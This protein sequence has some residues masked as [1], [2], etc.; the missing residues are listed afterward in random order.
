MIKQNKLRPLLPAFILFILLNGFFLSGKSMLEKWDADQGV[1]LIGNLILFS[2]TLVSY[3]LSIRG[4]KSDNPHA[5]VRSVYGSFMVK[6][7]ICIIAAFAYI[8]SEKK[9]V[10]KPALF[11]C[12]GLYIVYS[13]IEVSVLTK[14]SKQKKNA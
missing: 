14:L 4:L 9:N 5:A 12:M 3:L 8:M 10:N 2:V 13:V 6:F 7:F 11:M 1:L